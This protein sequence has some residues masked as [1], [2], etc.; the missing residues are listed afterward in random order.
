MRNS[1]E[2]VCIYDLSTSVEITLQTIEV[3]KKFL[4]EQL[5]QSSAHHLSEIIDIIEILN[6]DDQK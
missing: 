6:S 3:F 2:A 5:D 4:N 1:D